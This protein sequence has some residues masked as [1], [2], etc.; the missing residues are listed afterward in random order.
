MSSSLLQLWVGGLSLSLGTAGVADVPVLGWFSHQGTPAHEASVDLAPEAMA[1][2]KAQI[3]PVL[4]VKLA[5]PAPS[6]DARPAGLEKSVTIP[7]SLGVLFIP[8][9][10][11]SHDGRFD[12]VV[13]FHGGAQIVAP[14][15]EAADVNAALLVVNLG[16]GSGVYERAFEGGLPLESRIAHVEQK[17]SE[18]GF[19][20][21]VDRVA[22]T[23]WS[24]GY[25]A[26][27]KIL[28]TERTASRVDAVLLADGLHAGFERGSRTAVDHLKMDPF[29]KFAK[30]AA[31][32]H[33]L[34]GISHS[35]V[36][37]D[38]YASTTQTANYLIKF[39]DASRTKADGSVADGI[40]IDSTAKRGDFSVL[41]FGGGDTTA[42]CEHVWNMGETLF[43][44]LAKRWQ[45]PAS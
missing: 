28:T 33:G 9:G 16:V 40:P 42:H 34:M 24:A 27:S 10:F 23:A 22:L 21:K 18:R 12:L 35:M 45:S 37:T 6:A 41:G 30:R 20:K 2:P 17:V 8:R 31:D 13:H 26:V 7:T 14:Q 36:P 43:P 29:A 38:K 15:F 32:G 4:D 44:L 3:A 5:N 19:G 11:V 1:A 25:G 39:V